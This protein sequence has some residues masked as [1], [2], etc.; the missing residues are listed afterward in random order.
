[1][2]A[3]DAMES[4]KALNEMMTMFEGSAEKV[5][6]L[7]PPFMKLLE[8]KDVKAWLEGIGVIADL[9]IDDAQACL[10]VALSVISRIK[11][12]MKD[13]PLLQEELRDIFR[14]VS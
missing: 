14:K 2:D 7:M 11:F 5:A 12:K 6:S 9:G 3:K 10:I 8:D 1:M 4:V 13:N